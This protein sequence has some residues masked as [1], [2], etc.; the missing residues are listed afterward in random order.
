MSS[1]LDLFRKAELFYYQ[2]KVD[3]TFDYYQ[4][5]IKKIIKDENVTAS[6]PTEILHSPEVA[7]NRAYPRELLG[8][9]WMNFVGFFKD[10]VMRK[11]KSSCRVPT[12]RQLRLIPSSYRVRCL[13]VSDDVQ[14]QVYPGISS[15]PHR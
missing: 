9:V 11:D 3:D 14:P 13:Q 2:G 6:L 4:R 10:P 5:A 12:P 1:G 7:H 15:F 8:V